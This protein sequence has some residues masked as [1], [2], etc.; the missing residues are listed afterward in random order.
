MAATE[1]TTYLGDFS[2]MLETVEGRRTVTI[3]KYS[4]DLEEVHV[5]DNV[6][7]IPVT[8]FGWQA[9]E[10]C[11]NLVSVT[12]PQSLVSMDAWAFYGCDKL[13]NIKFP[14]GLVNLGSGCFPGSYSLIAIDVD[15]QN[16]VYTSCEGVLLDKNCTTLIKYPPGKKGDYTIPES[17]IHIDRGAFD[18]CRELS[19][20][21]IPKDTMSIYLDAFTECE[22]LTGFIVNENNPRF[23][24]IDG[25]LFH[26][27]EKSLLNYP[28]GNN[29]TD[30]I[31]PDSVT[32]IRHGAFRE[33]KKLSSIT[34]PES[35][36]LIEAEAFI[37]CAGLG[38]IN[39]PA[40][41]RYIG[42]DAFKEC[43][44]LQTITLSI[45]TKTGYKAFDGISGKLVYRD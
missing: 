20:I 24:S 34:L 17:V 29:N 16:P 8:A 5:P 33:C 19:L 2:I 9:F 27:E 45:T 32:R 41:L 28:R 14:K 39:L 6:G 1:T 36:E 21:S 40:S 30:Y 31:V 23:S 10:N 25:V 11:K 44:N 22:G 35:L 18:Y 3:E 4:G 42:E 15:E 7:G 38:S 12:L 26:K 13:K 43:P 37:G